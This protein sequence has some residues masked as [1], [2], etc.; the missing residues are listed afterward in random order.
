MIVMLDF[1]YIS[2]YIFAMIFGTLLF[3][4]MTLHK[5]NRYYVAA[6]YGSMTMF[7]MLFMLC[8]VTLP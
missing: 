5:P 8:I 7:I 2:T 1:I 3:G 4:W 6:M